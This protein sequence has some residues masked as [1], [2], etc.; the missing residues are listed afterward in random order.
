MIKTRDV[1]VWWVLVIVVA[2]SLLVVA[3]KIVTPS[4]AHQP[5]WTR[6]FQAGA[7]LARQTVGR[8]DWRGGDS[9][10]L[11]LEVMQA[12]GSVHG[13]RS[14]TFVEL[15]GY[16][17]QFRFARR[18]ADNQSGILMQSPGVGQLWWM[19]GSDTVDELPDDWDRAGDGFEMQ[20]ELMYLELN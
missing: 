17:A 6:V 4:P 3:L 18:L 2:M 20:S 7:E 15:E 14:I 5:R 13:L 9:Q 19:N 1:S 12:A 11:K 8:E 16:D 10:D